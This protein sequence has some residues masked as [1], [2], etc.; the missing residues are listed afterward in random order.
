MATKHHQTQIERFLKQVESAARRL[1]ADVRKRTGAAA[2]QKRL[3]KTAADLDKQTKVLR[4]RVGRYVEHLGQDIKGA[5][6]G[7]TRRRTAAS[8]RKKKK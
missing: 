4:T 1:R 7:A 6:K 8:L 3:S 5:S 2:V